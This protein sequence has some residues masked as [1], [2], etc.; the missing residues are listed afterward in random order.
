VVR[1]TRQ[2]LPL[3]GFSPRSF[4][5]AWG[6]VVYRL[7]FRL[8]PESPFS[9]GTIRRRLSTPGERNQ[10]SLRDEYYRCDEYKRRK[11]HPLCESRCGYDRR[12]HHR[13]PQRA[14]DRPSSNPDQPR[15]TGA[16]GD[17]TSPGS[18]LGRAAAPNPKG[19][20]DAGSPVG[21]GTQTLSMVR[22]E[23]SD[24]NF[25]GTWYSLLRDHVA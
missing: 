19:G 25:A 7:G 16:S 6:W 17:H 18:P 13:F 8:D 22:L 3:V 21:L 15:A 20:A 10:R 1:G 9:R 12:P 4:P 14:A 2:P 24:E 5:S 23:P 11:E